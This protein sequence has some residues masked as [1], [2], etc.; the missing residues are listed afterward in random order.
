MDEFKVILVMNQATINVSKNKNLDYSINLKI[1]EYL[2]DEAL[3]FKIDKKNE[4]KILKKVGVKEEKLENVYQ[5]LT[6]PS[7][8]YDLERKGKL[9]R[10]DK[11]LVVKYDT[12]RL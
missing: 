10:D 2:K 3:F 5:K 6:D 9:R 11:N 8:F 1:Q 12:T 7:V 4:L